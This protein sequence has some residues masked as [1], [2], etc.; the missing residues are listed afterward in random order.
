MTTSRP[1][2]PAASAA[3]DRVML[4]AVE[5]LPEG[6]DQIDR[7]GALRQAAE[8]LLAEAG[9]AALSQADRDIA[10]AALARLYALTQ[11]VRA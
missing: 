8:V 10:Q 3:F 4:C 2:A 1:S 7:A 6:L 5:A 9:D 11:E